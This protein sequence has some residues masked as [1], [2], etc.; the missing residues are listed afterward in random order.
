MLDLQKY[1][2][3]AIGQK[4]K[5]QSELDREEKKARKVDDDIETVWNPTYDSSDSDFLDENEIDFGEEMAL[6]EAVQSIIE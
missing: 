4:I 6:H 1:E 3:E 5:S 2:I